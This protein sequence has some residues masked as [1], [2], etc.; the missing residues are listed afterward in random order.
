MLPRQLNPF[1]I[2]LL[3]FS[4][5]CEVDQW[6]ILVCYPRCPETFSSLYCI[7]RVLFNLI[8]YTYSM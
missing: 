3:P 1:N 2:V 8:K 7:M 4:E 6:E 5:K